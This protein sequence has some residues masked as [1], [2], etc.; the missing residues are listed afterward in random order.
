MAQPLRTIFD[1][2]TFEFLYRENIDEILKLVESGKI[3]VYGCKLIRDE[4]RDIPKHL[5][6][7]NKNYRITLLSIYDDLTKERSY[8]IETIAEALAEEYWKAYSG[9]TPKRNIIPDFKIVALATIHNL[10]IIVSEDDRTM[11]SEN[12]LKVYK[13]VNERNGFETPKFY[14]IK[15]LI[16]LF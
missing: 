2:N 9:G 16:S 13:E 5:K 15:R 14:S 12:S 7:D 4:L 6:V 10:D 11:K 8:P 1:T 3:L